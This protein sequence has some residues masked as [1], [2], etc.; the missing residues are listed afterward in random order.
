MSKLKYN[1]ITEI[2]KSDKSNVYLAAVEGFKEPVV[3]KEIR[4]GSY[5]VFEALKH[6]QSQYVPKIYQLEETDEGLIVVEEYVDGELL[7]DIL[8]NQLLTEEDCLNIA[9][10]ICFA[11]VVLHSHNPSFIH[12]DIKPSNI[13]ITPKGRVKI[14]D[15][16]SSRFYKEEAE[17]DTRC[18]GTE[19]YAAPEQYGFA[20]TDC[21]SDIYS[22]GVVLEKFTI[23][24]SEEKKKLWNR[25]VER[26]TLFSPDSRYQTVEEV[27]FNIQKVRRRIGIKNKL[28]VYIGIMLSLGLV[29]ILIYMATSEKTNKTDLITGVTTKT[30]AEITTESKSSLEIESTIEEKTENNTSDSGMTQEEGLNRPPEWR[31]LD[32]D[33]ENIIKLKEE[34]RLHSAVV[35]YHFKDRMVHR[36]FLFHV[37][38]LESQDNSL[39]ALNLINC[40]S[41][42]AVEIQRDYYMVEDNVIV[43]SRDYFNS[44]DEGYYML[45]AVMGIGIDEI[46]ESGVILY[47]SDSD[48]LKERDMYLQN[49]T[50]DYSL[51][52]GEKIHL[53]LNNDSGREIEALYLNNGQKVDNSMYRILKEGRII[54]VSNELLEQMNMEGEYCFVVKAKDDSEL[55]FSVNI[56][57]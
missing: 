23:F 9:E 33:S 25:V 12:R 45:R 36:D 57:K 5:Q 39:L 22:L 10:Q 52:S 11:L 34:I 31:N 35:M 50:F 18:L 54:E 38:E 14:I 1:V 15:Y 41:D 28:F 30:I 21:R 51:G 37:R 19:K 17:T 53:V 7:S 56:R 44:L 13:I 24:I 46:Y 27:V 3:V 55:N 26:C 48:V 20:Q 40:D 42:Y 29:S 6:I 32:S 16:D 8:A 43:I 4:H 49:T 47:I 2:K